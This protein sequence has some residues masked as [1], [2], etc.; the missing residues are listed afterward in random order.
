MRIIDTPSLEPFMLKVIILK[1]N[2]PLRFIYWK[3]AVLLYQ[4]NLLALELT[5]DLAPV[6]KCIGKNGKLNTSRSFCHDV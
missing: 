5:E 6:A 3:S 2:P 4:G 1:H